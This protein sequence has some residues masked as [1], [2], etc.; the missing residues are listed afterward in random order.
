MLPRDRL[1]P[2]LTRC[3]QESIII[4]GGAPGNDHNA[5][6]WDHRDHRRRDGPVAGAAGSINRPPTGGFAVAL[7][8][9]LLCDDSSGVRRRNANI[10]DTGK[11]ALVGLATRRVAAVAAHPMVPYLG[12]GAAQAIADAAVLARCLVDGDTDVQKALR[13]YQDVRIERATAVQLGNRD[14]A[15]INRLPDGPEQRA[16]DA[17]F[18]GQDPLRHD[19][20]LYGHDAEEAVIG[21]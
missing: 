13:V 2:S 3:D 16:R 5:P 9:H 21:A 6:M 19:D 20:W 11:R 12:Q 18:A 15:G 8:D 1:S 14:R 7:R 17:E 4:N 10:I